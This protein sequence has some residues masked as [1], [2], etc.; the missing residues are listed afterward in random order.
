M[1]S[2]YSATPDTLK[3]SLKLLEDKKV[4]VDNITTEYNLEDLQQAID[5]TLSNKIMKAYIRIVK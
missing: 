4:K 5:D 3:T 2:S 1:L